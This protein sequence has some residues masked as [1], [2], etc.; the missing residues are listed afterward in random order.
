MVLAAAGDTWGISSTTFLIGY[1]VIAFLVFG[2]S[3]RARHVLADPARKASTPDLTTRP[4]DAAFLNGGGDLAVCSA[5]ASLRLR[6]LVQARKGTISAAGRPDGDD[7]ERAI[8]FVT[9]SPVPRS[10]LAWQRPV[11]TALDDI[12]RRL[13]GE[14]LLLSADTRRRIR[15]VGLWMLAVAAIGFARILAGM[16]GARPV[17]YLVGGA[18]RRPRGRRRPVRAGTAAHPRR[19]PAADRDA[20]GPRSLR[21][22]PTARLDR[23][24][25]LCGRARR[26][27]VRGERALGLR[28]GDGR[29]ARRP[30]P[31]RRRRRGRLVLGRRQRQQLRRRRRRW[32]RRRGL[33]RLMTRTAS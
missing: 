28:P 25:R 31:G 24:R 30:A 29:G 1:A 19:R 15:L 6:G 26:R 4:N 23:L 17:G 12:E 20:G 18:R 9:T 3:V 21:A 8:M 14:G 2:A 10:R 16:A 5:L 27:P 13:V 32:L 11:R 7:L 33:R 22:C